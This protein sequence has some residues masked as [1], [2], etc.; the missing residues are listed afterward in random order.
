MYKLLKPT[1][2]GIN[3]MAQQL[4]DHISYVGQEQIQSLRG[5]N[6]FT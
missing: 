3:Y 6:V 2:S 4:K 1:H 5:D